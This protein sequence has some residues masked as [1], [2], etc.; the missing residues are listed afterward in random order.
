MC[1]E[2]AGAVV[3]V[4]AAEVEVEVVSSID[5]VANVSIQVLVDLM[6]L[7]VEPAKLQKVLETP[8]AAAVVSSSTPVVVD[9]MVLVAN[10]GT[11]PTVEAAFTL[12]TIPASQ[13]D[14]LKVWAQ[15]NH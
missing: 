9:L 12:K 14:F 3:R 4:D 11:V 1:V 8:M 6:A 13:W 5:A 15:K 7:V 10:V 2:L